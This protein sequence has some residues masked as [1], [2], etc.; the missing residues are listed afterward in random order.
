MQFPS[1]AM[2]LVVSSALLACSDKTGRGTGGDGTSDAT[3]TTDATVDSD[4]A[5][6]T[7]LADVSDTGATAM[8]STLVDTTPVDTTPPVPDS[9][10]TADETLCSAPGG[11]RNV[12]DLQNPDCADH[13]RPEPVTLATALEVALTGLVITGTFGDTFTVEDPRGGPY[14]GIAIFNHGLYAATAQVGDLVDVTGNYMEFF[15]NSQIYLTEMTFNGTAPVP[16]P[17][18]AEHPAHLAT[19]GQLAELFEGVLVTV[20]DVYTTH[21]QP[22]CPNDYGEFEVTGRLRIDDLGYAW[23]AATGCTKGCAR[24]GDHFER[25]TGP[26]LFTFGNHKIEPRTEDDVVVLAKGD[27]AGISKCLATD[28]RA[29]ADAFVSHQVVINEIMADPFGDDTDQEW[30]ELY[31]PGSQ[32]INLAG[33]ALRDCGDQVVPLNGPEAKIDAKGYLVVGM[34]RDRAQNG[35][36]P[37]AIAYGVNGFYLPNTIGSVLLYD[38]EGSQA[39]LVDQTRYSRFAPWD[40]FYSGKSLERRGPTSDGTQPGSWAPGASAYGDFGNQGTPAARNDA[41]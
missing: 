19:N 20:R 5:T 11:T 29:R 26:L 18:V 12:Y 15:E 8:D 34:T 16:L 14:S 40:V 23:Q 39:T 13:P 2:V 7:A 38:G 41:R 30:I 28:C 9:D 27:A 31:N 32:P 17:F 37:V 22:D 10:V 6:D 33:W 1:G 4:V 3:D 21:T 36:V 25:I 35:G 24:L